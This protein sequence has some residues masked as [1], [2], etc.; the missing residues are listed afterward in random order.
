ML[1]YL[2]ANSGSLIASAIAAGFAGIA[3]VFKLGWAKTIGMLSP[4]RRKAR[5]AEAEQEAAA[6]D[7]EQ[8]PV[9]AHD[10]SEA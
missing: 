6:A 2:D 10:A 3:V 4:K 7:D 8:E 9:A 1:A 5:K